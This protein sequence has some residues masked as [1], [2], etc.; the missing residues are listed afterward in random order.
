MQKLQDSEEKMDGKQPKIKNNTNKNSPRKKST[1]KNEE[2]ASVEKKQTSDQPTMGLGAGLMEKVKEIVQKS[3]LLGSLKSNSKKNPAP[4]KQLDKPSGRKPDSKKKV[5]LSPKTYPSDEKKGR[6][7]EKPQE[8]LKGKEN[9]ISRSKKQ[10]EKSPKPKTP[11]TTIEENAFMKPKKSKK[12]K[13]KKKNNDKEPITE[14]SEGKELQGPTPTKK[15]GKAPKR[16]QVYEKYYTRQE[17]NEGLKSGKLFKGTL[18]ILDNHRSAFVCMENRPDFYIDS[19]ITRNRA[20]H[21]DIVV[22]EPIEDKDKKNSSNDD[23]HNG[24]S[25]DDQSMANED[26]DLSETEQ[27]L[28]AL[29]LNEEPVPKVDNP[30]CRA[31]VVSIEKR[32]PVNKIVGIIRPPGWSISNHENVSTKSDYAIFVPKDKRMPFITI[33]KNDLGVLKVHDWIESILQHHSK[34]F[35]AEI[36][37]WG[38]YSRY[39]MGVLKEELGSVTNVEDYTNALLLENGISSEPFSREVLEC[40][41]AEDWRITEKELAKRRDFRNDIV[42]TIDPDTAKDLDD[43]VSCKDLGNGTYEVGVH[44]ADV[45]HFMK[46]DTPLDTEAA[47]RATT[48]YLVQKAIPMLPSLL[49]ERLCSLNPQVER[50]AFSVTWKMNKE[51]KEVG[52]RW[53]GKSVIKTCARLAYGEAQKIIEGKSWAEGVGKPIA[54]NHSPEDVEKTILVLCEISRNLRAERFAKGAVEINSTELKFQLDEYGLPTKC[55]VYEQKEANHLIEE[56]MLCANRSVA[57]K[58][59]NTFPA[60]ALLRRHASPKEKQ[61]NEFCK[62]MEGLNFHFDASSSS[63][64]NDSMN[65]LRKFFNPDLVE[66]FENM[67]VRSLNRAEYFCTG[68]YPERSDWHHYALSFNHYTHFTSPIRRYPDVIV[69]RLLENCLKQ[70]SPNLPKKVCSKHAEHSNERREQANNVQ[71]DSQNLFLSVFISE[72]CKNCG[73][74]SMPVTAFAT[75]IQDRSIDVYVS[76]YGI[77]SRVDLLNEDNIKSYTILPDDSAVVMK[78]QDDSEFKIALTDKFQVHLYSDYSR[79][80]FNVRCSLFPKT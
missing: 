17:V 49:C 60:N 20:L 69:H 55:E 41:P 5:S 7:Q 9:K 33:H 16:K 15:S 79:T 12:Q 64:F 70:T 22:V 52:K 13:S 72:Y 24:S 8:K 73:V 74:S 23:E 4:K 59:S 1:K 78:K 56:F 30:R 50:L 61:I 39:P 29:E 2:L 77:S 25:N 45:G 47:S 51:G 32:S 54:G 19:P 67:A 48:V 26:G 68:D 37:R 76:Q 21:N 18:R 36:S 58:I 11:S 6:V 66:L 57:E 27:Q 43:A 3:D 28:E 46:P 75:R 31:K 38:T 14:K 80:F 71:E 62:F 42:I 34:L 63:A 40:L 53:F 65:R 35:A 44:I 10:K